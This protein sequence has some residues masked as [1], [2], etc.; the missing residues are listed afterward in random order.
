MQPLLQTAPRASLTDVFDEKQVRTQATHDINL[1]IESCK[2]EKTALSIRLDF[3]QERKEQTLQIYNEVANRINALLKA[4]KSPVSISITFADGHYSLI[5]IYDDFRENVKVPQDKLASLGPL[6]L[7]ASQWKALDG[8]FQKVARTLYDRGFDLLFPSQKLEVIRR[9]ISPH[10]DEGKK[11]GFE[12]VSGGASEFG[13]E[14]KKASETLSSMKGKCDDYS[15]LFMACVKKL[16]KDGKLMETEVKLA[17]YSYYDPKEKKISGHANVLHLSLEK[18]SKTYLVDF[19]YNS[20][21]KELEAKPKG[22]GTENASLKDELLDHMNDGRR[23]EEKIKPEHLEIRLYDGFTGAEA[24]YAEREGA[25]L[26]RKSEYGKAVEQ[27]TPAIETSRKNGAYFGDALLYRAEAYWN[28]MKNASD[29][30]NKLYD[31]GRHDEATEKF[32]LAEDYLALFK[33][34]LNEG[35]EQANLS[36]FA[37][38]EGTKLLCFLETKESLKQAEELTRRAIEKAPYNKGYEK[39]LERIMAREN[40]LK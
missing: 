16:K 12:Y 5:G 28:L 7:T 4:E 14:T 20:G 34:D 23:K 40:E 8:Q 18:D 13:S 15:L 2:S 22:I 38:M 1:L 9:I 32:R 24:Y 29:G 39:T 37:L 26:L 3:N 21:V 25:S 10:T 35:I 30:A 17:T 33:Y 36:S 6:E 19:T 11:F 27:L 31:A